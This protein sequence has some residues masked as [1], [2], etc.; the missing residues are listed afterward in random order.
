MGN[1]PRGKFS[2]SQAVTGKILS[3]TISQDATGKYEISINCETQITPYTS[4]EK[5][6][7]LDLGLKH[8]LTTS[9]GLKLE[10]P[11]PYKKALKQLRKASRI[12][13]R[14][15]RGSARY[16]QAKTKLARIHARVANVRQDF[17]YKTST[18]IIKAFGFIGLESLRVQN[19][20]KNHRLAQSI[21]DA[22]WS[23]FARQLE[24]K[25]VW[26]ER[27]VQKTDAFYPSSRLCCR[28]GARD[29]V[30]K[31]LSVR[32]WTCSS[33]AT[34]H[35]RD[36]NAAVNV[37]NEARRIVA[38]GLLETLNARGGHVSHPLDAVA[39]K[40]GILSLQ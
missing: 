18:S 5:S 2:S 37:E 19:M 4:S 12:L 10:A 3:V 20:V 21:M 23:E 1:A 32:V 29:K 25:A 30:L 38:T 14:R 8:F 27:T 33:C 22:G 26:H 11:K 13:S 7:G 6:V 9:H 28:C 40:P 36:E 35:D 34:V 17:L 39:V 24:Y 15:T 16:G 31:D